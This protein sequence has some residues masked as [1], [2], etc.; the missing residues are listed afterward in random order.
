[1]TR[2]KITPK[3]GLMATTTLCGVVLTGAMVTGMASAVAMLSPMAAEAQDYT[4][5]A[6]IGSVSDSAGKPVA[7]ATVTLTSTAQGQTRTLTS[8]TAGTFS[9]TGLAPGEYA[10]TV[11]A[12]GYDDFT[13]T[14]T[15][16]I[17]QEVRIDAALQTTGAATQTV[18]VKGKRV[19]QDFAKTT[20][21]LVVDL[22]T[23][24]K[25]Q[26]IGRSLMPEGLL[27]GL[28]DKELRDFF[29]Y[30]RNSQPISR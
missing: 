28:G 27:E 18:V 15:V 10:V 13:S 7:G 16:V 24:V 2:N 29:A 20:T 4:S 9:A 22:D 5:G 12:P 30:L 25:Q 19:R 1:M 23:L 3:R 21:G 8:S 17:S 26:P 6:V 11:S 14:L